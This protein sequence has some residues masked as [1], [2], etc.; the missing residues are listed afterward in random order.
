MVW[1]IACLGLIG[2]LALFMALALCK[3]ADDDEME[4][5]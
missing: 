2:L 3:E 1:A 5:D 4:W